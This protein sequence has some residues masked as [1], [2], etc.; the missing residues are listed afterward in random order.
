MD[1]TVESMTPA[2]FAK[3]AGLSLS[4][5]Y[6]LVWSGRIQAEKIDDVWAIPMTELEK[7]PGG[8]VRC[9][10]SPSSTLSIIRAHNPAVCNAAVSGAMS[11]SGRACVE[12]AVRQF[13][14]VAPWCGSLVR[15][16]ESA[17]NASNGRK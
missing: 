12:F 11:E 9:R 10:T 13:G 6:G 3:A 7:R 14:Q 5:V 15:V 16:E 1:T 8:A 17:R 2:Q 4:Y